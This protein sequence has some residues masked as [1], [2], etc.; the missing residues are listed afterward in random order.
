MKLNEILIPKK[1]GYKIG[2]R[3]QGG[4]QSPFMRFIR[5]RY[6]GGPDL[7]EAFR[8]GKVTL[9]NE[10]DVYPEG[11][12][13]VRN[14]NG[15]SANYVVEGSGLQISGIKI[16]RMAFED[17]IDT[18]ERTIPNC[19]KVYGNFY[20]TLQKKKELI[21]SEFY[22]ILRNYIEANGI[23]ALDKPVFYASFSDCLNGEYRKEAA[24]IKYL[25]QKKIHQ[26]IMKAENIEETRKNI[27]KRLYAAVS[28]NKTDLFHIFDILC[29]LL[30]KDKE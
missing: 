5:Y 3:Q 27:I 20:K 13:I 8:S 23:E 19:E 29:V 2:F 6:T 25:L 1:P 24:I 21:N 15:T 7:D 14:L 26:E 9:L 16:D 22:Q 4:S 30:N 12:I 17:V 18:L 28:F 10:I 11:L